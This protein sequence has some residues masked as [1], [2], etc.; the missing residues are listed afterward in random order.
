MEQN[1]AKGRKVETALCKEKAE[2]VREHRFF[3][4]DKLY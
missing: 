4:L 2:L 1:S 3:A